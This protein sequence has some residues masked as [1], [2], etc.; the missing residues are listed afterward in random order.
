[1]SLRRPAV[2]PHGDPVHRGEDWKGC[3]VGPQEKEN[4]LQPVVRFL[5]EQPA[6]PELPEVASFW[7]TEEWKIMK[8]TISTWIW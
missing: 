2:V 8:K 5:M 4:N 3:T 1:M 6:A 7:R